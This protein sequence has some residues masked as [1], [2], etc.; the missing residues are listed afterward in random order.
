MMTAIL[1]KRC[2]LAQGS[3]TRPRYSNA[4]AEGAL[5]LMPGK[6]HVAR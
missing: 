5:L 1:R 3:L 4:N 2:Y 6:S